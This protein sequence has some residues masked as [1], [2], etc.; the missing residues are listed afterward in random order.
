MNTTNLKK[1]TLW[2]ELR[3]IWAIG[4]K[5]LKV[6]TRYRADYI[7]RTIIPLT[8]IVWCAKRIF[9]AL[10]FGPTEGLLEYTGTL[11][12]T[13]FAV[14]SNI[15]MEYYLTVIEGGRG[16][17]REEQMVGTLEMAYTCPVDR[18]ILIA[19]FCLSNFVSFAP[20]IFALSLSVFLM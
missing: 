17:I 4:K 14:I 7:L 12:F 2:S 19:G 15:I 13:S 3:I 18:S 8:L 1:V 11:D 9:N 5:N 6:Q 10:T 16:S 20:S